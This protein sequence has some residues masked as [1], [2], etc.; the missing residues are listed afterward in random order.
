MARAYD[1]TKA[2]ALRWLPQKILNLLKKSHYLRKVRDI[3]VSHEPDLEIVGQLVGHGDCVVDLGANIGVYT[4]FLSRLVTDTGRVYSFEPVPTTFSFLDNNVT[5]LG[6]QN[7]ILRR[8][9]ITDRVCRIAMAVPKDEGG[10][11][12]FYQASVVVAS[13]ESEA[14]ETV[15]MVDGLPLDQAISADIEHITFIKCDVE[16]HEL[17]CLHGAIEVISRSR[18]AWLMEVG[19]DPMQVG[20][21]AALVFAFMRD[22]GYSI[23]VFRQ[24]KLESWAPG[25]RSINYLFLRS[26]HVTRLRD[27][28]ILGDR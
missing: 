11:E 3:S 6:L 1:I 5:K 15:T 4:A 9:A 28:G 26:E 10:T 12:N 21:N 14:E 23:W 2:Y 8:A 24:G 22:R 19:G 16:G 13:K 17:H 18:P 20:S 27:N 25:L 7:V